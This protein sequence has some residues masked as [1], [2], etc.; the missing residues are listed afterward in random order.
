MLSR[1]RGLFGLALALVALSVG[2]TSQAAARPHARFHGRFLPTV[3]RAS[4][5]G[6][7]IT[8]PTPPCP[9][10][11]VHAP[12]VLP[13][14]GQPM[15]GNMVYW[16]GRVQVHPKLYLVYLG[17]GRPGAF[18]GDCTSVRVGF[19]KQTGVLK[20]DPN[21]AGRYMADFVSQLGGTEWAGV[22]SQYYQV[23]DGVKTFISNDKNQLAGIWI[24]DASPT[25][26]K[27]TYRMMAQ[28]AERA[29]KHFK[30]KPA[31]YINSNFIIAEPKHFSDPAAPNGYCAFHDLTDPS[32]PDYTGIT[33]GLPYTNMP[34]VYDQGTSCGAGSVNNGAQGKLDGVT[35]ALGHE[36]EETT[37][38]PGAEFSL[39]GKQFGAW[40]DAFDSYENGDKCA[41]IGAGLNGF[42]GAPGN[43]T[44]NR[45][46]QFA[47]QSLWSNNAAGGTGYCAGAGTDLGF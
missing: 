29:A 23:V 40:Y 37:T 33:A 35:L 30:V 44:G 27:L 1:R 28:E 16:G 46:S 47:V 5:A 32:V 25:S 9:V 20:C 34:Y 31:D 43:I 36:I 2:S 17:W 19:G 26:S 13:A 10:G 41:Y 3:E 11:C 24:D 45:G 6:S 39:N 21:G 12:S 38:D 18:D 7:A 8:P 15:P 4:H 22:Q 14:A 42:P